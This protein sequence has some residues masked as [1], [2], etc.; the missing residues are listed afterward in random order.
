MSKTEHKTKKK[1]IKHGVHTWL[2]EGRINPS[3]RGYRKLQ[4][5]LQGME[6]ALIDMQG[7]CENLTPAKEI[8]IKGTIEAYGVILLASVYCKREGILRPDL[9]KKGVVEL[10]PVMGKQF[11]S[12]L[13]TLRQ[14]LL[15]LGLDSKKA[16]KVLTPWELAKKV[17]E[18]ERGKKNEQD[19]EE[20]Q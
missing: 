12:F 2:K 11:L 19:N 4:K 10:Q 6:G 7:G 13:N 5:Y 20:N 17:E 3:V 9:L 14:N 1:K 18:K 15:A 8:L 16:D